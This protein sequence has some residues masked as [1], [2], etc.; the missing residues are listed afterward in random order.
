M[1]CW[2]GGAACKH[3]TPQPTTLSLHPIARKLLL[4]FRPVEGRRLSWPEYRLD[5]QLANDLGEI[6][7]DNVVVVVM[8]SPSGTAYM[9]GQRCPKEMRNSTR[10]LT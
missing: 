4:I 6:G 8:T 7:T 10:L 1:G 2:T 5:W 3:S 9:G